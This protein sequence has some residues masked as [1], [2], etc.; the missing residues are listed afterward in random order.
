[1]IYVKKIQSCTV[2]QIEIFFSEDQRSY[3]KSIVSVFHRLYNR[4]EDID[5]VQSQIRKSK[6]F[7]IFQMGEFTYQKCVR[8]PFSCVRVFATPWT[9]TCQA[10][11]SMEFSRQEYWSRQLFPPPG[12][13]PD[14]GIKP[15]S[16][17]FHR[18][19]FYHLSHQGSAHIS[20]YLLKD[21]SC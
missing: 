5:I 9:V 3:R 21:V 20:R 16:P 19:I 7:V 15:R 4:L 2:N 17:T 18:Q 13:L 14:P 8:Q 11:L 12:D 1:M 6:C 10:P